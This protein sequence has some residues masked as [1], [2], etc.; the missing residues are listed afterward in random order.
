MLW[1]AAHPLVLASRSAIRRSLLESAGI[2]V[3]VVIADL[4][5]R[6]IEAR[7]GSVGASEAAVLLASAKARA[8]AP[9]FADQLVLGAD[10][11]L[12]L[13]DQRFTKPADVAAARAQLQALSGCTHELCSGVA[14][15][16]NG[17][18]IFSHCEI[19]RMTMRSLSERF[20]DAY[21][22][23]AGPAV[24]TSVG[25]YQLEKLGIHL[26]ERIEGDHFTILGL[27]LMPLFDFLRREGFLAA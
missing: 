24:S 3:D 19:A 26:F 20:L 11:T 10:Q 7:A 23:S 9:A 8:V 14:L 16:R 4:D 13:G 6:A 27:P 21:L 17:E 5:E 2:P 1:L 25:G 12:A 18:V 15:V 22:E